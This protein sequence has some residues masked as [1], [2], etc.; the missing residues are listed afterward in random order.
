M[1]L[2]FFALNLGWICLAC[3]VGF[4][5]E[6]IPKRREKMCAGFIDE[7]LKKLSFYFFL[8]STCEDF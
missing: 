5:P 8:I 2:S 6:T 7:Y 3:V 4:G 1:T